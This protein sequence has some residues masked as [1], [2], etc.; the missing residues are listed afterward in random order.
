MNTQEN[1]H[2]LGLL[3]LTGMKRTYQSITEMPIDKHPEGHEMI[4]LLIQAEMQQ[5]QSQKT[6]LFL[7][8]AKL[9]YRASLEQVN[10]T[11]ERNLS[12]EKLYQLADSTFINRSENVL[13]TG[14]T[15]SGKSY[16]AC[17]LGH[18]ACLNGHRVFYINMNRFIEKISQSRV[19][20]TFIKIINQIEKV[21]LLIL[22]DFGLQPMNQDTKIALLQILEDRY[23]INSTLIAS[24]LPINIWF[25]YLKE[26]TIA[27]AIM[28]RLT[29][30]AHRF[31]LKGESLR[32]K[33][34]Y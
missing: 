34:I 7:R 27:D 2:Q 31:E 15:G 10:C 21:K 26:P 32:K 3:K 28:D 5:R 22:D 14:A 29:E 8:M 4:S 24:Q 1:L 23:Q 33:K 18:Q 30:N 9:R 20:G 6:D 17:A 11:K 12:R 19:D 13:I 16:L 25:D